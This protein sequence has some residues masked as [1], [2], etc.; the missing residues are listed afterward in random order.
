METYDIAKQLREYAAMY[1]TEAFLLVDP[2]LFMHLVK[3]KENQETMAFIASSLSYGSRKQFIPKIRFILEA[4]A[5]DVYHWVKSG[6]YD[7]DIP[8]ADVCY[9]RLYT[10]RAVNGFLSALREMLNRYGSIGEFVRSN[11]DDC[12][13]ALIALTD[14]FNRR[15]VGGIIPQDTTSACKRLCMFMRW[16]VRDNSAVDLGLWAD[17]IDRRTLIMP[18]DTHVI[19]QALRLGLLTRATSSMAAAV[20]LTDEMRKIFPDDPLKGDFALFGYG[21]NHR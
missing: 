3:G 12:P 5:K 7:A 18:L 11:A 10:Y 6:E 13:T 20:R 21:I 2:S 9:Y 16:M 8:A 4:S 1:E 17:F 15:S 14:F 19:Q